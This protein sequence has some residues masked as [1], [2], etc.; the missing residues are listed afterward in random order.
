MLGLDTGCRS[1]QEEP[2]QALVCE[3]EDSHR[4]IVTRNVS[5]YN[6][7]NRSWAQGRGAGA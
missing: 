5:S 6:T 2:L 3:P 1:T 7:V 4:Q